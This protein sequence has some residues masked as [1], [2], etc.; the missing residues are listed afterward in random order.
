MNTSLYKLAI[1][2]IVGAGLAFPLGIR[3]GKS[4]A[5]LE[6]SP[7]QNASAT[8]LL[9]EGFNFSVLRSPD[10][11][12]RGP[13][14]GEKIDLTRLLTN[15]G[16]T[17]ASAVGERL[18][19]LVSV[20]PR[21]GMCK[22]ARDEMV[23]LRE[24]LSRLNIEYCV[25]SFD[26]QISQPDFF[27]YV[28]SLKVGSESYFWSSHAGPPLESLFA[29]TNP[30]HLLVD[31]VGTVIRVWPGSHQDK[32]VRDRMAKQILS[33]TSVVADTISALPSRGP[34]NPQDARLRH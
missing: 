13:N 21:C 25:V 15:D 14:V 18:T 28:D 10:N 29:M 16:R 19:M 6:P 12:W 24:E 3:T 20:T 5:P 26:S 2:L 27:S 30:T 17:L 1:G 23:H 9:T 7:H 32:S 4:I 34:R 31:R 11:E 8:L 33:D 22:I